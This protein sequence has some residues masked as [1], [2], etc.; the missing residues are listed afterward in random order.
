MNRLPGDCLK[1]LVYS[2]LHEGVDVLEEGQKTI[3]YIT[4]F[5]KENIFKIR[6]RCHH[7]AGE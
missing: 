1:T 4:G 5:Y 7:R 3:E 6:W 2:Q